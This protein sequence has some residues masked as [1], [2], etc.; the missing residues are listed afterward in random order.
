MLLVNWEVLDHH[1]FVTVL[2]EHCY[3]LFFVFHLLVIILLL[4]VQI[5]L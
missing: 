1:A 5:P 3:F 2:L 4:W